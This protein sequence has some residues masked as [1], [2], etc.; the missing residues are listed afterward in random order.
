MKDNEYQTTCLNTAT[1]LV[2][3]G[4]SLLSIEKGQPGDPRLRFH[5]NDE[6]RLHSVLDRYTRQELN[7]PA[8]TVLSNLRFLKTRINEFSI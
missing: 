6:P 2:T 1:V 8:H 7:L 4:F 5:F 3:A